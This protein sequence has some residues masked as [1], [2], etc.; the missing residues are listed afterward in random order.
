MVSICGLKAAAPDGRKGEVT[1]KAGPERSAA[2]EHAVAGEA[3]CQ[4]LDFAEP[5]GSRINHDAPNKD[6]LLKLTQECVELTNIGIDL[7][8]LGL[9]RSSLIRW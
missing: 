2:R 7:R 1:A 4:D 3:R 6:R 5:S 9:N 8:Q